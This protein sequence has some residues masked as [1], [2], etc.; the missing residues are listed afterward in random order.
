MSSTICYAIYLLSRNP[1]TLAFLHAEHSTVLGPDPL[2][3]GE[4]LASSPHLLD[5][6]RY[7][8]AVIKETLRLFPPGSGIRQGAS[9]IDLI[10]E[11]GT[12]YPTENMLV[13]ILHT[14]MHNDAAY[15]PD[16]ASFLPDRWL[17]E[18]GHRLYPQKGAWRRS[19]GALGLA[20]AR[21]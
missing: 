16:S 7:T 10:G 1:S 12:H 18:P 3:A 13:W 2:A 19:S 5:R 21:V 17:V 20:L 11:D 6:L 15:W 14:A 8:T 9:G 4:L